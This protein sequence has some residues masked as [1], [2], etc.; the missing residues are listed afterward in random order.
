M[1]SHSSGDGPGPLSLQ[2]SDK[3]AAA[4]GGKVWKNE[5]GGRIDGLT[6]WNVGEGF[7]SLGIGHFIWYPESARDRFEESFPKMISFLKSNGAAV[8]KWLRTET[9]CP[10]TSRDDFL[11][12][13]RGERMTE[14]RNF[15][16]STVAL[17]TKYIIR[18]L[19]EAL[20]V[21]LDKAP[22]SER[23]SLAL[24]FYKVL[25]SGYNG[26]YALIDYVNF[27]G[28]GVSDSEKY[29][30]QGWGLLQV[31]EEMSDTDNP[32]QAFARSAATVLTRRVKNSPPER[33]EEKWLPGWKNRIA[34]YTA[35]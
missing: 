2:L 15:L 17:Q 18:R 22:A 16:A 29:K 27:K 6:S 25:N 7:P 13:T 10:W 35:S 26:A 30:G 31:L 28:E 14:L 4:I 21:V 12:D 5:C 9:H 11:R 32:V 24:R 8:P 3:D 33:H 23:K 34:T 19:E 1:N 20:P